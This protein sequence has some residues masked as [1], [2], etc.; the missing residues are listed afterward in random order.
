VGL[1]GREAGLI[2]LRHTAHVILQS[3]LAKRYRF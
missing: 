1:K 2:P 3:K